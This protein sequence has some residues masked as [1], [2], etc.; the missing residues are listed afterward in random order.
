[1]II[2]RPGYEILTDL[3]MYATDE[4]QLVER[5]GRVSYRSEDLITEQGESAQKFVCDRI[6]DGHESV[7]E[8]SSITIRFICDRGISHEL[9]RHRLV[10]WTQE[11]TRYCNYSRDKFGNQITVIEPSYLKPGSNSYT[12]CFTSCGA[13]EKAYMDMLRDHCS[14]QEARCVLPTCLKTELV[15][16]ANFR[17]WRHV[18]K[19][20]T[21]AYA[22]PQM[23]EL[24]LPLLKELYERIP[25]V[26]DDIYV[27]RFGKADQRNQQI[28]FDQILNR[29]VLE[30][31]E[32]QTD[33]NGAS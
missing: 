33:S 8:H 21:N 25:V 2:A 22:H 29:K 1:M 11:S 10:S 19:E 7:I 28:S 23:R 31:A 6:R 27:L 12:A 3:S 26:F 5:A 16:T 17:E 18:L 20:R 9:V 4:L 15:G 32:C 13:S 30:V 14:A 24:M